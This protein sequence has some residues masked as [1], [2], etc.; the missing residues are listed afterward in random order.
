MSENK[1]VLD[2]YHALLKANSL[3]G[4]FTALH[5]ASIHLERAEYAAL[6]IK[7]KELGREVFKAAFDAFRNDYPELW[8]NFE[9]T[10]HEMAD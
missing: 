3:K 8:K 7:C 9:E 4:A 2:A 10:S 1:P 6:N 5:E